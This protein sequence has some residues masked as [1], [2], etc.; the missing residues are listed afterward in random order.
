MHTVSQLLNNKQHWNDEHYNAHRDERV[1]TIPQGSS[2]LDAARMMNEHH[3]GSLIATDTFGDVSGIVSE[4][5]I[6]T[7]VVASERS[8]TETI[9]S[10][11]MTSDLISC[12][13]ATPIAQAKDM[14]R[15]KR[16][17]H[18]PVIDNGSLVG[19]ISIGDLNAASNADLTIEVKAM[20]EYITQG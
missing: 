4:R 17:R 11:V 8:P 3:I 10:D 14:M 18:L 1:Y 6:L 19:M 2:I 16:I 13:P 12:T 15:Q 9:V 20:R 5:D 7:R